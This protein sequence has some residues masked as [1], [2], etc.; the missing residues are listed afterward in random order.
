MAPISFLQILNLSLQQFFVPTWFVTSI[1]TPFEY[2]NKHLE[3]VEIFGHTRARS[4]YQRQQAP[5][6]IGIRW[7]FW[8]GPPHAFTKEK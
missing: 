2:L 5:I 1:T 7:N 3:N 4:N 6:F 8:F